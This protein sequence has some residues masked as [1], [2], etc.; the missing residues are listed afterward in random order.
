MDSTIGLQSSTSSY[1]SVIN[2][3]LRTAADNTKLSACYIKQ[4]LVDRHRSVVAH[5]PGHRGGYLDLDRWPRLDDED[6]LEEDSESERERERRPRSPD[7]SFLLSL[8]SSSSSSLYLDTSTS[9]SSSCTASQTI[10]TITH[11]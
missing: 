1:N 9:S 8:V 6:E 10:A 2:D 4:L 5:W 3:S 11:I 7:T